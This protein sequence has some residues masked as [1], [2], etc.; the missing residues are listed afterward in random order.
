MRAGGFEIV[1]PAQRIST[2]FVC[3]A[4]YAPTPLSCFKPR[5]DVVDEK[6]CRQFNMSQQR[7]GASCSTC[8][9]KTQP[10]PPVTPPPPSALT[11]QRDPCAHARNNVHPSPTPER[12]TRRAF[13][14]L[15]VNKHSDSQIGMFRKEILKGVATCCFRFGA[16]PNSDS[17]KKMQCQDSI[18][19][20]DGSADLPMYQ[21]RAPQPCTLSLSHAQANSS[22]MGAEHV[23][24]SLCRS[25]AC[26]PC[27]LPRR[28]RV[29]TLTALYTAKWGQLPGPS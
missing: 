25:A 1:I 7:R 13:A 21:C 19:P 3:V 2:Y 27:N 20:A 15:R 8:G 29:T 9:A 6:H 10:F 23:V 5:R 17:P 4:R 28:P 18:K 12:G 16:L 11:V 22:S 26:S 24:L 14:A